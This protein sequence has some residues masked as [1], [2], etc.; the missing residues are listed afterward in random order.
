M[1]LFNKSNFYTR[2]WA[3]VT[4][5]ET[6]DVIN[7]RGGP[8]EYIPIYVNRFNLESWD[9]LRFGNTTSLSQ[10]TALTGSSAAALLQQ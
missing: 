2:V 10:N 4:N 7:N 9:K 6:I 1:A 3:F 8:M 5:K